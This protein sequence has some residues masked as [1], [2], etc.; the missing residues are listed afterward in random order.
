MQPR[1]TSGLPIPQN[2]R[3]YGPDLAPK[4]LMSTNGPCQQ[5]QTIEQQRMASIQYAKSARGSYAQLARSQPVAS[6]P[7]DFGA[8]KA[9]YSNQVSAGD[10][11]A[12][13]KQL[14]AQQE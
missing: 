5:Q 3:S 2:P 6:L 10:A 9:D 4:S 11:Q 14:Y 1:Y 12:A 8:Q 13:L 7:S